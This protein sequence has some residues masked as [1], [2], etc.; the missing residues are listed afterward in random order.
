MS[1]FRQSN[2][3]DYPE[4]SAKHLLDAQVL[5]DAALYDGAGYHAGYVVECALKTLLQADHVS[6]RRHDLGDLSWRV[7]AL[8]LGGSSRIARYIPNPPPSIAYGP[9]LAGWHETMRYRAP[10]DLDQGRAQSWVTEAERIYRC[11]V[12]RMRMDGVIT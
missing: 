8:A 1:N 9:P 3:D 12:Q 5:L 11:I 2:G 10:G 6:V 4:A 7:T